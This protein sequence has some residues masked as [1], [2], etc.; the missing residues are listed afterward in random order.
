MY[1]SWASSPR[2]ISGPGPAMI[3]AMIFSGC[4][5]VSHE[6]LPGRYESRSRHE[7]GNG[8]SDRER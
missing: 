8:S 1:G 4:S 2:S 3:R 6:V 5:S 7:S